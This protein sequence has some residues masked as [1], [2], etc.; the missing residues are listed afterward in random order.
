MISRWI[1]SAILCLAASGVVAAA[2]VRVISDRTPS[3]LE[4]L[5]KHYESKTGV[6][7]NA[8]FVKK[9]LIARLESRPTEADL[10]ITKTADLLEAAKRRGVLRAFDNSQMPASLAAQ[11]RDPDN[12]Y[13]TT[14]YRPRSIFASRERVKPGEVSSYADLADPKWKGRICIRSGYHAYNLSL[15]SQML[16]DR[17]VDATRSFLQGLHA[18]LARVP[19]GN[20]RAQVRAIYE[21][22]C[23]LSVGNSYYMPLM[24]ANP[25][26]RPW[27]EATYLIFPDQAGDGSYILRGGAG[28][29]RADANL[30]E[31][32]RFLAYLASGEAQHFVTNTTYAYP[33]DPG[34]SLPGPV[35]ALGEGQPGVSAGRFKANIIPL[36]SIADA[37]P[38]VV[39]LLDEINFDSK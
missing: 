39:K 10:V 31:A 17:G 13:I 33:V 5:F 23:D 30:A 2:E 19:T 18:N 7:I 21:G 35:Q 37:R 16:A 38:D 4:Q 12:T 26:Q 14:S 24:L 36:A 25:E 20:D 34:L 28:L 22:D 32:N 9:G 27:G 29:T 11:F 8:V 3:H 1:L 6:K 15:F